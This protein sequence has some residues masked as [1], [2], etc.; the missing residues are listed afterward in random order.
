MVSRAVRLCGTESVDAPMHTL[1]AGALSAEFDNGALRYIKIGET[2]V[3]RA[4]AFLVRDE[5]WGTFTPVVEDL[6]LD[7]TAEEFSVTYRATCSDAARTLVY[8]ARITGGADG[9]LSFEVSAEPKTDVE[10]NRTGFI[11]LHPLKGVAGKAVKVLHVDGRE[12]ASTFPEAIDPMCPFQDIRA[13]SHEITPGV[14]ATCTMEG[15]TFEMEDQRNWSDASYKTYVRPLSRPWPY[16]LKKGHSIKQ[17]VRLVISG[18]VPPAADRAATRPVR[19]DIGKV[20]GKFPDMGLG[21]PTEEAAHALERVDLLRRLDPKW[22]VCQVDLR[23]NKGNRELDAYRQLAEATGADVALEIIISGGPRPLDELK[24]LAKAADQ[25]RLTP[26]AVALFPAQDMKSVLPGSKWPEMPSFKEIYGAAR[27]AFPGAKLGGGMA[28]Y[29]TELN[30]K[31][32]PADLIDYVTHTTCPNVHAADDRS[33]MET[34]ETLP[35]QI[36]STRSFM[37]DR[38][39]YRIGPSQLGCRENPY[40]KSTA[41]NSDNRRVCLCRIDPRQR[42]LF[43]AA[44]MVAYAAAVAQGGVDAIAFGAPTGPFGHIY[45]RA[46]FAQPYFDTLNRP[47]VYPSFHVFAGLSQCSGADLLDLRFSDRGRLAALAVRDAVDTVVLWVA[48]LTA[49]EIVAEIPAIAGRSASIVELKADAFERLS[50]TPDFLE[51][52][53]EISGAKLAL[54]AYAVTRVKIY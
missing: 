40:G 42:G 53:S 12:E 39:E 20:S 6:K 35:Y 24:T 26:N 18:T 2:E 16:V 17:A 15:D 43:N 36:L 4:I 1:R 28:T 49:D 54:D 3:I 27:E 48:N 5:N 23:N 30:R 44:W 33:V 25:A 37:G 11:V 41:A 14:W 21:V 10:T 32:P 8:D 9:S 13:L 45:R 22:L 7:Q 52:E 50:L 38:I 19:I 31:R 29:F 46:E 51:S 47:A 34:I